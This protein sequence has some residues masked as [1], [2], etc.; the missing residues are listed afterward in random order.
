MQFVDSPVNCGGLAMH[1]IALRRLLEDE[2]FG[3]HIYQTV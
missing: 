2:I 3:H 1:A